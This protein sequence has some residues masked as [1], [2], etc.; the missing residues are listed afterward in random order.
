MKV[1]I[2]SILSNEILIK[3]GNTNSYSEMF[4]LNQLFNFT[5]KQQVF[6]DETA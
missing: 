6:I 3:Y 4:F 5:I 2:I 1:E